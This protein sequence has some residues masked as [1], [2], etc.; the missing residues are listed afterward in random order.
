[1]SIINTYTIEYKDQFSEYVSL[2]FYLA[3]RS[4]TT[5]E[6]R[7]D[8]VKVMTDSYVEHTGLRPDHPQLDR[9]ATLILRDE[10]TD[11][12]RM[13]SRNNEYPILSDDQLERRQSEEVSLVL[14]MEVGSDGRDYRPQTRQ[15]LRILKNL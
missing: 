12:D 3:K 7:I 11:K 9:L 5:P 1:M 2:L 14:A 4:K 8:R 13:K 6:Q 15:N 10:L